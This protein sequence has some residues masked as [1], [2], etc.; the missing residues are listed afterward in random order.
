MISNFK[1]FQFY[2]TFHLCLNISG[3][4][5]HTLRANKIVE[6]HIY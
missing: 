4:F 2:V 6:E 1:L 3:V 5:D